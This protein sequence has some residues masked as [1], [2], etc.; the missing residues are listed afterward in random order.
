LISPSIGGRSYRLGCLLRHRVLLIRQDKPRAGKRVKLRA[1][2]AVLGRDHFAGMGTSGIWAFNEVLN[3]QIWV[4][5]RT[6][7]VM[8]DRDRP[9]SEYRPRNSVLCGHVSSSEAV[10]R[11]ARTFQFFVVAAEFIAA[12]SRE[13]IPYASGGGVESRRCRVPDDRNQIAQDGDPSSGV[14]AVS[15]V[16][17]LARSVFDRVDLLKV[18]VEVAKWLCFKATF[19]GLI[20]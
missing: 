20:G 9:G 5:R 17:V 1:E 14:D 2:G 3:D 18:D 15:M 8:P 16:T 12:D 11:G 10:L 4:C 19:H 6:P 13:A 7:P